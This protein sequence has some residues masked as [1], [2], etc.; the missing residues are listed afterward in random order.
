MSMREMML[1]EAKQAAHDKFRDLRVVR[2]VPHQDMTVVEDRETGERR[3]VAR[4]FI[5]MHGLPVAFELSKP[6]LN[7]QD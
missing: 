3:A 4:K 1:A 7:F 5:M 2:E 6:G